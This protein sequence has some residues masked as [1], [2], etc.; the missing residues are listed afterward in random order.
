MAIE[1]TLGGQIFPLDLMP[2]GLFHAARFLPFYYQMYFPAAILT[3]RLDRP[4]ALWEMA[5]ELAWAAILLGVARLLWTRGLRR[6][7]AV[8]G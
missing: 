2:A 3:G 6:H 5:V 4:T 7:T 8:G 1:S